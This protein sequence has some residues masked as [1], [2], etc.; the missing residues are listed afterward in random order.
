MSLSASPP[1]V[2]DG[3][4]C[5]RRLPATP[6]NMKDDTDVEMAPWSCCFAA[7][8]ALLRH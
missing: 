7:A 5:F 6:M 8:A 4:K 2:E 3:Y 1:A